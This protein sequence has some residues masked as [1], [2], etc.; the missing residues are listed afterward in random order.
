MLLYISVKIGGHLTEAK[1]MVNHG[2]WGQADCRPRGQS[3]FGIGSEFE[4]RRGLLLRLLPWSY[5][6][7]RL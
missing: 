2:V 7:L 4:R 3:K 5:G 1:S 6:S